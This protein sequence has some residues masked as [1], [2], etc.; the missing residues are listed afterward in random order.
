MRAKMGQVFL[1]TEE[2][3]IHDRY[4][5]S[6]LQQGIGQMTADKSGS[7]AKKASH[8]LS[9]DPLAGKRLL[10]ATSQLNET[11]FGF[12]PGRRLPTLAETMKVRPP[13]HNTVSIGEGSERLEHFAPAGKERRR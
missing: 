6:L 2:E 10:D 9:S 4:F 7:A 3:V 8:A 5:V 12:R 13:L 11:V 1:P